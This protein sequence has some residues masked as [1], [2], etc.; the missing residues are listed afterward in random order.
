MCIWD[1]VFIK[2]IWVFPK[3]G[4]PQNGWFIMENPINGIPLILETSICTFIHSALL[5]HHY[6]PLILRKLFGVEDDFFTKLEN[7]GGFPQN[8]QESHGHLKYTPRILTSEPPEK[9]K[10]WFSESQPIF[11]SY[12]GSSIFG[13]RIL[14]PFELR[15]NSSKATSWCLWRSPSPCFP[16]W[17]HGRR[18]FRYLLQSSRKSVSAQNMKVMDGAANRLLTWKQKVFLYLLRFF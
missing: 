13:I 5:A 6:S 9:K 2:T 17:R 3:I 16:R 7:Y 4:V 8:L 12:Y 10:C 18:S 1:N 14:L 15:K 11:Y